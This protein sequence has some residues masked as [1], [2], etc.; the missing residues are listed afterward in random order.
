MKKLIT[1]IE[2]TTEAQLSGNAATMLGLLA[3]CVEQYQDE[4]GL[5]PQSSYLIKYVKTC[6]N[7]DMKAKGKT[8]IVGRKQLIK[9]VKCWGRKVG[10]K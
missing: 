7:N 2:E 1:I 8:D 6:I 4:H 9:Y 3:H 10:F 5:V